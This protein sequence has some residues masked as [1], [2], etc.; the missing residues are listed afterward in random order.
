MTLEEQ[1]NVTLSELE[2]KAEMDVQAAQEVN[3][4]VQRNEQIQV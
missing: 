3:V 2:Q 1:L 4:L